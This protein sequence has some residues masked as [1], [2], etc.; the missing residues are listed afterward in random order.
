MTFYQILRYLQGI[1]MGNTCHVFNVA[2][3]FSNHSF[4]M[5]VQFHKTYHQD[6]KVY[7]YLICASCFRFS[8]QICIKVVKSTHTT[9]RGL[10]CL[11]IWFSRWIIIFKLPLTLSLRMWA[12]YRPV[13]CQNVRKMLSDLISSRVLIL[14]LKFMNLVFIIHI[15]PKIIV[16]Y[17]LI[18]I[19]QQPSTYII[20][21]LR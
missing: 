20:L 5:S 4:F 19:S 11:V 8:L 6:K 9:C 13:L 16:F 7:I 2:K 18:R 3:L 15:P 14:V 10:G 21:R 17:S 1:F 12:K